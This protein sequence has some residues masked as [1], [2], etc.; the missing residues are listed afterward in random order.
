MGVAGNAAGMIVTDTRELA[1]GAG[2]TPLSSR[3]VKC[4]NATSL[5][6]DAGGGNDLVPV[7][8]KVAAT[9][10]GGDGNDQIRTRNSTAGSVDC[11]NGNDI[12]TVDKNMD[13]PQRD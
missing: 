8:A 6:L 11:D 12:A 5:L 3:K 7:T 13:T 10:R 4:V 1:P 9:V 2:C